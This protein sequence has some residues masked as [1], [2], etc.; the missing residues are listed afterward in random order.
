MQL[1]TELFDIGNMLESLMDIFSVQCT[2]KGLEVGL[3][4][5]SKPQVSTRSN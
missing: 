3:D 4:M 2:A 5:N 1:E